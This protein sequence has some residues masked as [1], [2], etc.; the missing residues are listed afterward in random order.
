VADTIGAGDASVSALLFS[1]MRQPD[2]EGGQ[3]LRMAVAAGAAACMRPGA[4]PP[5]LEQVTALMPAVDV[6]TVS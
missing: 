6:A 4:V 3:R 2:A 5:T 1:L